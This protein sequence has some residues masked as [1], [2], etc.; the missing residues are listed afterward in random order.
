MGKYERM[1]KLGMPTASIINRMRMDGVD[2]SIIEEW[3]GVGSTSKESQNKNVSAESSDI[4]AIK[5]KSSTMKPF[6]W[7][8]FTKIQAE[9]T[10]WKESEKTI[11]HY[12]I[13]Y[14]LLEEKFAR[15]KDEKQV[16]TQETEQKQDTP[17]E[18]DAEKID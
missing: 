15:V 2:S 4:M 9:N 8:K 1:K 5:P 10:L 14:T 12:K 6:H 17:K 18:A 7:T 3:S 11:T 13:D 16:P